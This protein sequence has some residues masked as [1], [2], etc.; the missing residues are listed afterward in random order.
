VKLTGTESLLL[1]SDDLLGKAGILLSENNV[2]I[3]PGGELQE[4]SHLSH[5]TG[6]HVPKNE[7]NISG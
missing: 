6:V 4:P 5:A 2:G 7:E 3:S 1:L